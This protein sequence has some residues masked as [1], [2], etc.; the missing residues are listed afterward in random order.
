MTEIYRSVAIFWSVC[1]LRCHDSHDL[2]AD[3]NSKETTATLSI[4]H[5]WLMICSH[6]AELRRWAW[7][8]FKL[9]L[10]PLQIHALSALRPAVHLF[11]VEPW[12]NTGGI[13]LK[14][15]SSLKLQNAI[16]LLTCS[17]Q[18]II[19][20]KEDGS[21]HHLERNVVQ[22]NLFPFI[23]II[24]QVETKVSIKINGNVVFMKNSMLKFL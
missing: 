6:E 4:I 1:G 11:M 20:G 5:Q 2:A 12:L 10:G 14:H 7:R 22:L 13:F 21:G 15:I 8:S 23:F 16:Y 19:F 18:T 17:V 24:Q 9:F 3:Q